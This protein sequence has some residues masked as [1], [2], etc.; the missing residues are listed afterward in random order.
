MAEFLSLR[1][2]T[3][4]YDKRAPICEDISFG[5]E[6]DGLACLLG[7]S[8]CGKTTILRLIAGFE[9]VHAGEIAIA[10][11]VL[12]DRH[13]CV[14]PEQRNIGFVF[15]DFALFPHLTVMDNVQFGLTRLTRQEARQRAGEMLDLVRMPEAGGKY[16]HELSG[17]Q[18]QRVALARALAPRPSL[19]LLDEPFSSLDV[20][21]RER[22]VIEVRA[23][24]E[25][26]KVPALLVTHDQHEA[27]AFADRVGVMHEGRIV[28]WDTPYNL[29]HRPASR[30]VADFVGEGVLL[31][32]VVDGKGCMETEL[33]HLG[34]GHTGPH[35]EGDAVDLLLRPDDIVH[36]DDSEQQAE[37]LHKAFRGA[38]FLYA[39]KLPSGARI[40]SLVPSH[41]NH[42]I[43]QRIG[44]RMEIDHV[45]AFPRV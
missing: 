31:P 11:S 14:P 5:I 8:G 27:F 38:E 1:N 34:C 19:M 23:L 16:P 10:G 6:P 24:L 40:L 42:E 28:Q 33:G 3:F 20:E 22:L 2:V 37:V 44:I 15:Q 30:F 43:G 7:P 12:S 17:G 39:L 35:L 13:H 29:Y 4:A 45:V 21:L 36:D 18:R 9:A 26:L 41:H 25:H 32:A